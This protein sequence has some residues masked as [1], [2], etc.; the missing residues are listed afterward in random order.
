MKFM[1]F[2]KVMQSTTALYRYSS[3]PYFVRH[4]ATHMFKMNL[5]KPRG[6]HFATWLQKGKMMSREKPCKSDPGPFW[7][8]WRTERSGKSRS[9]WNGHFFRVFILHIASSRLRASL[10]RFGASGGPK[11]TEN[12]GRP[13]MVISFVSSSYILPLRGSERP[14]TVLA[15]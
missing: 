11:N 13:E 8:F 12:P 4:L 10:D 6:I 2:L 7:G 3:G 1:K 9:S 14:W 5:R 15:F